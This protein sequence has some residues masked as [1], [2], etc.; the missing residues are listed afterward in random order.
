MTEGLIFDIKRYAI[1]DGPGIRTTVFFKGCPLS[2]WWCHNP[3]GKEFR[4][5]LMVWP[6]RC[7]KCQTCKSACPNSAISL[8]N[9]SLVTKRDKC[10]VCGK[11]ATKCPTNAREIVGK[12]LKAEDVMIE[13]ET[14]HEFYGETGGLTVSGGEPLAQPAFL[15]T[16]LNQC[17]DSGI[18]TTLDTS[19]YAERRILTKIS[20]V[21]DL[22]LYDLK[23]MDCKKHKQHTG[24]SNKSIIENLRIL[25]RLGNQIIVR[26][27]LISRINDA[28]D[29]ITSMCELLSDLKNVGGI[30][31][32]PYHRLGV[33]KAK[34]LGKVVR[35]C[36]YPSDKLLNRAMKLIKSF[37]LAVN[38]E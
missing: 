19:G 15:R 10:K 24:V 13:V 29:N 6:N 9:N 21:V 1:H 27:P 4:R 2:C 7:I 30:S 33:N 31:I 3:E 18:H 37:G 16:L 23:I 25:D 8:S 34:R 11:C 26:F 20:K 36:A 32:L 22:F 28:E 5:E 17:K 38:L 14:D 12:T 35:A